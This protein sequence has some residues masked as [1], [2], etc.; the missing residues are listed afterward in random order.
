MQ[1]LKNDYVVISFFGTQYYCS[2]FQTTIYAALVF[3]WIIATIRCER[4][5]F[6]GG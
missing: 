6:E 3:S 1:A 4:A 5:A 2:L